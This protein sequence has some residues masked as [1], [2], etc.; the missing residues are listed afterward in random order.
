MTNK[1]L[2]QV[3]TAQEVGASGVVGIEYVLAIYLRPR[4]NLHADDRNMTKYRPLERK[5][6]PALKAW[7]SFQAQEERKRKFNLQ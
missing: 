6:N 7:V 3:T 1:R 5:W 2:A 4:V